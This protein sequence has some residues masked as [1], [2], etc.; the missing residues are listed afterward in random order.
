MHG[1]WIFVY[2]EVGVTNWATGSSSWLV[3]PTGT[4]KEL[5]YRIDQSPLNPR[6][7]EQAFSKHDLCMKDSLSLIGRRY[8]NTNLKSGIFFPCWFYFQFRILLGS[9]MISMGGYWKHCPVSLLAKWLPVASL[10]L[11][12]GWCEHTTFVPDIK[13]AVCLTWV[14]YHTCHCV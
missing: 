2:S 11:F 5:R 14:N 8:Q 9:V 3:K 4:L 13:E 7:K 10:I 6:W 12:P 1:Q